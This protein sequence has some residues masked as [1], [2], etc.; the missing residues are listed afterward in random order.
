M[1]Y[2]LV[3]PGSVKL[4]GSEGAELVLPV[5]PELTPEPEKPKD[6]LQNLV[7]LARAA[8]ERGEA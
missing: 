7:A 5:W 2:T 6:G 8:I 4:P 1:D 3:I